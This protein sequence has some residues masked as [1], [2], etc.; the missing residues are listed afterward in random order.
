MRV[1]AGRF[2]GR[3]LG[4]PPG[5]RTRPITDR[6]KESLFNILGHRFGSPGLLP[7]IAVLD[8]FAG[9]GA[10]GIE[11]LSR[12]AQS[13][14]F[15]ERDRHALRALRANLEKLRLSAVAHVATENAWT[16]RI[17]PAGTDAY[18]LIFVDPA[19]QDVADP[20]PVLALLERLAHRLSAQGVLVFRHPV[21][22]ELPMDTLPSLVCV[23]ARRFGKMGVLLLQRADAAGRSHERERGAVPEEA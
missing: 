15:V 3:V 11:S 20:L 4:A 18:G 7:D 6:A 17:P 8:L 23:D 13:C 16:M 14:L 9:S 12:G 19:Y 10:L 2:R 22:I 5:L 1:I 21:S